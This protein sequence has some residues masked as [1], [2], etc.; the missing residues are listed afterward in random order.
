MRVLLDTNIVSVMLRG[1]EPPL[2]IERMAEVAQ[3][4]TFTSATTA[5]EVLYGL[6][7]RPGLE[8]V[9]EA[10]ER[11]VQCAEVVLPFDLAAA[12]VCADLGVM[13]EAQGRPIDLS[14]LE[15]A[16]IALANNLTLIT[17][18]DRHFRRIPGLKVLN[19]LA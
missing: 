13:L 15:I 2:L 9:E 4:D 11:L 7:R 16:A 14:D 3:E 18:N 8:R 6:R 1:Q 5:R 17:G 19:W 12:R 10:F